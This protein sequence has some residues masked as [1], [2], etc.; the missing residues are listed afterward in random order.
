VQ[1]WWRGCEIEKSYN[2]SAWNCPISPRCLHANHSYAGCARFFFSLV[3]FYFQSP[4]IV[5]HWPRSCACKKSL[6]LTLSRGLLQNLGKEK[7]IFKYSTQQCNT[8]LA[9]KITPLRNF[10]FPTS[11]QQ[12]NIYTTKLACLAREKIEARTMQCSVESFQNVY[13]FVWKI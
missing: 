10:F 4:A 9:R 11:P 3:F 6:A 12:A 7:Y 1:C 5:V 2:A 13:F 8:G